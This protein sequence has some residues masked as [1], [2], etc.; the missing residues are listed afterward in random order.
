MKKM[1]PTSV[2][3]ALVLATSLSASL[4]FASEYPDKTIDVVV[5]YSAGGGTD[6]MART[7]ATHLED[8][9][10]K[11]AAVVVKNHPGAGGQIGFTKVATADADGYTLGTMNLPAALALTYDRKADYNAE[12][13]TWLANFVSDPNTLVVSKKSGI[14]SVEQL[15]QVAQD[16][17]GAMTVG[18]AALGGND[19]F[20]AI[21]FAKAANIK[22]THIPFKGAA[23]ARTSILGGHVN[24]GTMA[25]S[26]TVGFDDELRVLAVLSDK[27]LP[28]APN[29]PTGKEVGYNV[30]MGSYRGLV[31]PAGLPDATLK[32]LRASLDKLSTDPEF[33]ADMKKRG[34]PV[35]YTSGVAYEALAEEQNAIAKKIWQETPWK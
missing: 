9:L 16:K 7:I 15:I 17:H 14:T 24:M 5:G 12:S 27:R 8:Y 23:M 4:S 21:Q 35:Q 13:F 25:F 11:D 2:I 26:Q 31:A 3:S 10:G 19:H 1:K 32:K 30:V 28:Q 22:L 34:T 6:V 20:S 29:I 18:L 33:L